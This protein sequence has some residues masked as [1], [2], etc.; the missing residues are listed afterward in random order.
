MSTSVLF[1]TWPTA[2]RQN[3]AVATLNRPAS[4][5]G[6]TLEMCRSLSRQLAE[7]EADNSIA[8]VILRGAGEK[9]FCA[10]GDIRELYDSV[11]AN[12]GGRPWDNTHARQF[13]ETEYRLDYAIHTCSK[14]VLCWGSGIVFGGGVGLMMGSSHRVVSE[15][16]RFAM[17]EISIG[18][19]PDVGGTWM[20][21]RLAGGIGMF[22]ALTGAQLGASDCRFLGLADYFIES[23]KWLNLRHALE[24]QPWTDAR[25]ENDIRLDRVLHELEPGSDALSGPLQGHCALISRA[26]SGPDFDAICENLLKLAGHENAWLQRA[27]VTFRAGSPGSARLSFELLKRV[28]KLSLADAFR[29]E[30]TAALQCMAM[31]DFQEGVRA[32]LIDKDKSPR[33]NPQT[34]ASASNEWVQLFFKPSW[35]EAMAHPLVDLERPA[36]FTG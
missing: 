9:A 10:G 30:Y 11:L 17:P 4:M 19:F 33:W 5:N 24:E 8:L 14:P 12:V 35:P 26:C 13:F 21:G 32:L 29:Q 31:G 18:I 2:G 22:L 20:L 3:I 28:R 27:A 1:E 7:W 23:S 36:H 15:T 16:T 25:C 6:L 34:L